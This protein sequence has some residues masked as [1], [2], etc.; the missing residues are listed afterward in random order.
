MFEISC[1]LA[2]CLFTLYKGSCCDARPYIEEVLDLLLKD[3]H[4]AVVRS[5]EWLEAR[6]YA[7]KVELE[8]ARAIRD[9]L[10]REGLEQKTTF[11]RYAE[12]L[13]TLGYGEALSV[14]V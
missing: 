6:P 11:D 10:S 4:V 7:L 5:H 1:K 3:P 2:L 8:V 13:T 14:Q 12:R 9:T